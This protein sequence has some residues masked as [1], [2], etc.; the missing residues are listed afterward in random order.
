[1]SIFEII[2]LLCFGFAWP[3]SIYKSWTSESTGGKS[4]LFSVIVIL[5][6]VAGMIHKWLYSRDIVMILYLINTLMVA[7][8]LAI[9]YRNKKIEAMKE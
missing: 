9:Y 6:Y 1:M 8:D 3:V 2:M 5:G 4:P 7:A